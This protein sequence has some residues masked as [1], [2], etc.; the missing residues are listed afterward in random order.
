MGMPLSTPLISC[1]PDPDRAGAFEIGRLSR[2]V[3][4]LGR[5]LIVIAEVARSLSESTR[6]RAVG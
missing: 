2:G 5:P 1:G 6:A 4:T 3:V